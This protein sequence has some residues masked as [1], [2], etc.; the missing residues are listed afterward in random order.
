MI[1]VDSSALT[2]VLAGAV[3]NPRLVARIAV[4]DSIHAT[5]LL[6]IEFLGS[7]RGLLRGGKISEERTRQARFLFAEL[8]VVRYPVAVI[9]DRVWALRHNLSA[10]D[11]SYVALA[12]ALGCPLITTD[13]RI[14]TASGHVAQVEAF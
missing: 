1:V 6:D 3:P 5:D 12:E 7:L 10:Y 14:A 9:T 8:Q 13:N 11:A 2:A 4:E